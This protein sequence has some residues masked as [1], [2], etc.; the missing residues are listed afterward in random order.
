MLQFKN[1]IYLFVFSINLLWAMKEENDS[2]ENEFF[3]CNEFNKFK[4]TFNLPKEYYNSHLILT[5]KLLLHEELNLNIKQILTDF[6]KDDYNDNEKL[7][8][9]IKLITSI[10]NNKKFQL[11]EKI[12]IKNFREPKTIQK[13]KNSTETG[14]NFYKSIKNLIENADN[15]AQEA[16]A[17]LMALRQLSNQFPVIIAE[18]INKTM[19]LKQTL[20]RLLDTMTKL[21]QRI[22]DGTRQMSKNYFIALP[23]LLVSLFFAYRLIKKIIAYCSNL[24]EETKKMIDESAKTDFLKELHIEKKLE[25]EIKL[26]EFTDVSLNRGFSSEIIPKFYA[27]DIPF[28]SLIK[29]EYYKLKYNKIV[30]NL[31]NHYK[32]SIPESIKNYIFLTAGALTLFTGVIFYQE[33]MFIL[34]YSLIHYIKLKKDY[35]CYSNIA[36]HEKH[37]V[38]KL[39]KAIEIIKIKVNDH[40]TTYKLKDIFNDKY[41]ENEKYR[42]LVNHLTQDMFDEDIFKIISSKGFLNILYSDFLKKLCDTEVNE[43]EKEVILEIETKFSEKFIINEIANIIN[44]IENKLKKKYQNENNIVNAEEEITM[45]LEIVHEDKQEST[46]KN[47]YARLFIKNIVDNKIQKHCQ[48]NGKAEQLKNYRIMYFFINKLFIFSFMYS[49]VLTYLFF[50]KIDHG[51]IAKVFL[52][53]SPF[54]LY[55][56]F[57]EIFIF[58]E[59][60]FYNEDYLENNISSFLTKKKNIELKNQ[61]VIIFEAHKE[62]FDTLSLEELKEEYDTNYEFVLKDDNFNYEFDLENEFDLIL[63]KL[64]MQIKAKMI[65][66]PENTNIQLIYN[67]IKNNIQKLTKLKREFNQYNQEIITKNHCSIIA[68]K[69]KLLNIL[70]KKIILSFFLTGNNDNIIKYEEIPTTKKINKKLLDEEEKSYNELYK[71]NILDLNDIQL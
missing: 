20:E 68:E 65:E 42:F 52:F 7:D 9:F 32:E 22:L 33:L 37:I 2:S 51:K 50:I 40:L 47:K 59:K 4:I 66:Y 26:S 44:N 56:I 61:S 28:S 12:K 8:R 36:E 63:F 24:D 21:T 27:V 45:F 17:T 30:D 62:N 53:I 67:S 55:K 71:D 54:L 10:R 58:L 48:S 19:S 29:H 23:I 70:T 14:A 3:D 35:E 11:L 41:G 69:K 46:I 49:I 16:S 34:L 64:W 38:N 25:M 13:L 43:F 57:E 6:C 5:K 39:K 18:E 1:Y 60:K 31:I 15:T